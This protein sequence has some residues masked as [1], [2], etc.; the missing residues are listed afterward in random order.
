MSKSHPSILPSQDRPYITPQTISN[1]GNHI[2]DGLTDEEACVV[3]NL[4]YEYFKL[5]LDND[6]A[7]KNF[8]QKKK[9]KF[10]Q[11]HLRIINDKKDAK[12]SIW[13]LERLVPEQFAS[14]RGNEVVPADP[15]TIL[16]QQI[17]HQPNSP[18]VREVETE[19][20]AHSKDAAKIEVRE[21]L[22]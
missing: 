16:I 14:K 21:F 18:V 17:Q 22:K 12:N 3:E 7:G 5:F 13:L 20:N 6:P 19:N 8:I 10:K 1:I 11:E 4:P 15:L 9:I 2:L